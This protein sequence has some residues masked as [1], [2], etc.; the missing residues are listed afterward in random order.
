MRKNCRMMQFWGCSNTLVYHA[1]M[2]AK[3]HELWESC[4]RLGSHLPTLLSR[5]AATLRFCNQAEQPQAGPSLNLPSWICGLSSWENCHFLEIKL[6]LAP[7]QCLWRKVRSEKVKEGNVKQ[8][9]PWKVWRSCSLFTGTSACGCFPFF[10]HC[11][12]VPGA[13]PAEGGSWASTP[14]S[15]NG[16][17]C[18]RV[19]TELPTNPMPRTFSESP[20]SSVPPQI[21]ASWKKQIEKKIGSHSSYCL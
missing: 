21:K 12:L 3:D 16:L 8:E 19:W 14:G 17:P 11:V 6:N 7:G 1:F 18:V 4:S 20:R 5:P 13:R 2:Q 9:T 10:L 15:Y